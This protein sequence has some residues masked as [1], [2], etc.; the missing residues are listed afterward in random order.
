MYSLVI[1]QLSKTHQYG[2]TKEQC[3]PHYFSTCDVIIVPGNRATDNSWLVRLFDL[4]NL[5]A[6]SFSRVH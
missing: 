2:V 5:D 6:N 1:P 3:V 4:E